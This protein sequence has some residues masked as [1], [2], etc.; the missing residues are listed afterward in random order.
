[1]T[2]LRYAVVASAALAHLVSTQG[3]A[4]GLVA[5]GGRFIPPRTGRQHLRR[6][7]AALSDLGGPKR[8]RPEFGPLD[9]SR[10]ARPAE[11]S[12]VARDAPATIRLA[13]DRMTRRGLLLVI[14]DFY[15]DEDRAFAELRRAARMGHEIVLFQILSRAELEFPYTTDFEFTDLETGRSVAVNAAAAKREYKD[16]VAAFLERWRSRAGAEG[17]QYSL[18]VTDTPV[19]RALRTFLLAR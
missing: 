11:V 3:D 6:L 1:M 19:E 7:L 16:Q 4:V 18:V 10:T 12:P 2:K 17:F 13:A 5:P 15:D 14:S 9:G 8:A